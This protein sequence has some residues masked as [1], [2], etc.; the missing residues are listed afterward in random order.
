MGA[1]MLKT[2]DPVFDIIKGFLIVMVIVGHTYMGK[3]SSLVFS[4]HMPLFFIIAGYFFKPRNF[5]AELTVD[6]KRLLLPCFFSS[7]VIIVI[8]CFLYVFFDENTVLERVLSVLWGGGIKTR[9]LYFGCRLWSGPIW[10][11]YAMFCARILLNYVIKIKNRALAMGVTI[12]LSIIAINLRFYI[13]VPFSVLPAI[14]AVTFMLMG[15]LIKENDLL[16]GKNRLFPWTIICWLAMISLNGN[17]DMN[18]CNYVGF[19]VLYLLGALGAFFVIYSFVNSVKER[20]GN[21]TF[22]KILALLGKYCLIVF[23]VHS[24]EFMY[25]QDFWH[26]MIRYFRIIFGSFAEITTFSLR[27]SLILFLTYGI[28][29]IDILKKNIFGIE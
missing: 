8:S 16:H 12:V 7:L 1:Q 18:I 4:F 5:F 15:Y 24:I 13:D 17:M 14:C 27:L 26:W 21:A 19:F 6:F 23:S 3:L 10:F 9:T 25:L 2:R 22:E 20:E 28:S 11:L 29:K